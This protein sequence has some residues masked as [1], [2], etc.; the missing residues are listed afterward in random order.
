M[1]TLQSL[2]FDA[3]IDRL[4][5]RRRLT[6]AQVAQANAEA[7][8]TGRELAQALLEEM[9]IGREFVLEAV[10]ESYSDADSY[11][12]HCIT[13]VI[14]PDVLFRNG[15]VLLAETPDV[16]YFGGRMS[17]ARLLPDVQEYARGRDVCVLAL[18]EKRLAQLE[19]AGWAGVQAEAEVVRVH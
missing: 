8:M 2:P 1:T 18:S 4:L 5:E 10:E 12:G 13:T 17:L 19:Q 14:P 6:L 11:V 16:L 15:V 7:L 3:V 9:G